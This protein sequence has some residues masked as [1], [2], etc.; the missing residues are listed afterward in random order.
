MRLALKAGGITCRAHSVFL[1]F[2]VLRRQH[3][4]MRYD[5][6]SAIVLVK[7][8]VCYNTCT[9]VW[10]CNNTGA[11]AIHCVKI[12]MGK[13]KPCQYTAANSWVKLKLRFLFFAVLLYSSGYMRHSM[14]SIFISNW[15]LSCMKI[16]GFSTV[17]AGEFVQLLYK[18]DRDTSKYT[19][20][21]IKLWLV[22]RV[23]LSL[24]VLVWPSLDKCI[25]IIC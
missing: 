24:S 10:W 14:R 21:P 15:R 19:V 22:W 18:I 4:V 12:E 13:T 6:I 17:E 11:C 20:L 3:F 1:C 9:Q 5:A 16:C 8:D 2:S 7:C 23:W 25:A